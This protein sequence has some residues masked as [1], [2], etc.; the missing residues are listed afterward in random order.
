MTILIAHEAVKGTPHPALPVRYETPKSARRRYLL[1]K[2]KITYIY[3]YLAEESSQESET[4]AFSPCLD[5]S[6]LR[7][8]NLQYAISSEEMLV[9]IENSRLIS[10]HDV[11][12]RV[13]SNLCPDL[14]QRMIEDAADR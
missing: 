5:L 13:S 11:C 8:L 7:N 14:V 3:M 6:P 2:N 10:S 9:K 4:D 1:N 12:I